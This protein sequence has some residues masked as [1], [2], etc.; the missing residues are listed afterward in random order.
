MRKQQTYYLKHWRVN[1]MSERL[2]DK[3][4]EFRQYLALGHVNMDILNQASEIHELVIKQAERVAELEENY[5]KILAEWGMVLEE[6]EEREASFNKF[7]QQNKQYREVM[8][9]ESD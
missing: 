9:G 3:M 6:K 7:K 2:E 5:K 1:Q 8:E 4:V